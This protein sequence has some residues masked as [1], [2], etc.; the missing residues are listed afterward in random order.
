MSMSLLTP[1]TPC[2]HR[3]YAALCC[4]SPHLVVEPMSRMFSVAPG[5]TVWMWWTTTRLTSDPR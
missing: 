1:V 3:P 5:F 4:F 2:E